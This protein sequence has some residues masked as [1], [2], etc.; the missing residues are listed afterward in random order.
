[1][2]TQRAPWSSSDDYMFIGGLILVLAG[3]L[4]GYMLWSLWHTEISTFYIRAMMWQVRLLHSS[5]PALMRFQQ[6]LWMASYRPDLV[7]L[8]QLYFGL[9][10]LGTALRWPV[11]VMVAAM[12]IACMFRAAPGRFAKALDLEGLIAV[13][14]EMFPALRG[15]RKRRLDRLVA[16]AVGQPLPADPALTREEWVL[17]FATDRGGSYSKV[18]AVDALTRQ[19]G[20]HWKGPKSATAIE[21]VLLAAFALHYDQRRQEAHTLLGALSASLEEA[22]LD[23]AHGPKQSLN[24]PEDIVAK[25]RDI[26]AELPISRAIEALCGP[27]GWSTTALMSLLHEARRRSGVL[28]PPAFAITKLIDRP[29]WYALHSL[30]FPA[31]NPGE[32]VHP[33]PR[34]EALGARTHWAEERRV[35]RPVYIPALDAALTAIRPDLSAQGHSA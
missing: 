16:P 27:H 25:A 34:I 12:G 1:M 3:G 11:V 6:Q 23:G 26:L 19:L 30:G 28:A 33:N 7:Q 5:D 4:L 35:K 13:Q 22:G 18:G 21:Q 29:L 15:F 20:R 9:A 32:E 17:R 24:V 31:D 2:S 10:I 8:K 14:A